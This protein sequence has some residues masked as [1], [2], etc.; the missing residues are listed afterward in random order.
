MGLTATTLTCDATFCSGGRASIFL[1]PWK[2]LAIGGDRRISRLT[3]LVAARRG[4]VG[5]GGRLVAAIGG[6]TVARLRA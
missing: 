4:A 3:L 6:V 2:V 1:S 5:W